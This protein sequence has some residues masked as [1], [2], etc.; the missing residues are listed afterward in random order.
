MALCNGKTIRIQEYSG[1]NCRKQ[2]LLKKFEM[3]KQSY[4]ASRA[5][6]Q[7]ICDI[8][9]QSSIDRCWQIIAPSPAVCPTCRR[10]QLNLEFQ[11]ADR[12]KVLPAFHQLGLQ[13]H[14]Y[15]HCG[16]TYIYWDIYNILCLSHMNY[17]CP[18]WSCQS[19]TKYKQNSKGSM[20]YS[21]FNNILYL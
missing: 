11:L 14:I 8:Q 13:P 16:S 12:S 6:R 2:N 5:L 7:V 3:L 10:Q 1:N 20:Q 9:G 17:N 21:R 15:F 18:W 4:L 19:C